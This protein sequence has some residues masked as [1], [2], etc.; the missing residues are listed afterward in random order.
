MDSQWRKSDW[1]F[2]KY[3]QKLLKKGIL[4]W[5]GGGVTDEECRGLEANV[6]EVQLF[7]VVIMPNAYKSSRLSAQAEGC[8]LPS[9]H[10]V[11]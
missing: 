5:G 11:D 1:E 6:L 8:S 10:G 7:E 9:L 2:F 4:V 3:A